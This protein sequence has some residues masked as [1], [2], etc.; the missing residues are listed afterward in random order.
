MTSASDPPSYPPSYP[1][2]TPKKRSD[3]ARMPSSPPPPPSV[4]RTPE[5][6]RQDAQQIVEYSFLERWFP[7][8]LL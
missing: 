7:C 8:F 4:S 2:L 1:P 6:K 5:K 3:A